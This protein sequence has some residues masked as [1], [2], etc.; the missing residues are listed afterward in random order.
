MIGLRKL[1]LVFKI[2]HR[3]QAPHHHRSVALLGELHGQAV[4]ALHRHIRDVLAAFPQQRHPFFYGEQ[5]VLCAVDEHCHNELIVYLCS[6]LDDV[7]MSFR[8]R[9]K[10]PGVNCCCHRYGLLYL[11]ALEKRIWCCHDSTFQFLLQVP[12]RIA[13]AISLIFSQLTSHWDASS[14]YTLSKPYRQNF[15]KYFFEKNCFCYTKQSPQ[16]PKKFSQIVLRDIFSR[17]RAWL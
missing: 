2:R 12:G 5:R 9:V 15:I 13:I 16:I 8:D 14:W 7:E 3:P 4:E 17:K 6:S 11:R 10:W 1:D